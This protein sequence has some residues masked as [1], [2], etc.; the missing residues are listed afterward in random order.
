MNV[1]FGFSEFLSFHSWILEFGISEFRT[2]SDFMRLSISECQFWNCWTL[3]I[4]E[5]QFWISESF[6]FVSDFQ[7][8]WTSQ[9]AHQLRLLI[10]EVSYC[11]C[12]NLGGCLGWTG[13]SFRI[14]F[15]FSR[16]RGGELSG[17]GMWHWNFI[18]QSL[19]LW[20]PSKRAECFMTSLR[21]TWLASAYTWGQTD[22][23]SCQNVGH[24]AGWSC[25]SVAWRRQARGRP[26]GFVVTGLCSKIDMPWLDGANGAR[27]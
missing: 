13:A 3:W 10:Y 23:S 17:L 1:I 9:W 20:K 12:M 26:L 22:I 7:N 14:A 21:R 27:S 24:E 5:F 6:W 15:W 25:S 19:F 4:S 18:M 2:C 11:L 16:R 8:L